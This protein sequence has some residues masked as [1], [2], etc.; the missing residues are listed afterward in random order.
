MGN[1]RK[2]QMMSLLLV[3]HRLYNLWEGNRF[4][5]SLIRK[6]SVPTSPTLHER[7][8]IISTI[9][10]QIE[11]NDGRFV[12]YIVY[13]KICE[14]LPEKNVKAIIS[15]RYNAFVASTALSISK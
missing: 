10:D 14:V 12:K 2:K 9:M 6:F 1:Y 5:N 11:K 7:K 4:C 13:R 15:K 3:V 8:K